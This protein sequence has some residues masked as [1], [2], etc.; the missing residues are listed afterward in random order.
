MGKG[1]IAQT[2][3]TDCTPRIWQCRTH[4]SHNRPGGANNPDPGS[5]QV[6]SQGEELV[7]GEERGREA[8]RC[9]ALG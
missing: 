5:A 2:T 3:Q 8:N 6:A 4:P 9:G 7:V 1:I